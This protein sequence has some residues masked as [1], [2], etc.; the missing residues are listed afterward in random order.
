MAVGEQPDE[1]SLHHGLLADDDSADLPQETL[2]ERALL[3]DLL[4]DDLDVEAL[5]LSH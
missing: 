4:L 1:Q 5:G 3:P 2:H